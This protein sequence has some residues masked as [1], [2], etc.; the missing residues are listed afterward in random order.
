[1]SRAGRDWKAPQPDADERIE[2][3]EAEIVVEKL[4][5]TL[6]KTRDAMHADRN[7]QTIKAYKQACRLVV[8]ARQDFRLAYPAYR[9]S[10]PAGVATYG[11]PTVMVKA[12]VEEGR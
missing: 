11:A 4:Q 6:E 1:M 8:D 2:M 5:Q 12:T 9:G 7:P 3:L 10:T